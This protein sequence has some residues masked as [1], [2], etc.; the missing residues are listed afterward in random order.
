VATRAEVSAADQGAFALPRITVGP[1]P[2]IGL[3]VVAMVTALRLA[4]Q[5]QAAPGFLEV[6]GSEAMVKVSVALVSDAAVL[7]GSAIYPLGTTASPQLCP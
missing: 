1:A 4:G 6:P 7:Q 5:D 2:G 3:A